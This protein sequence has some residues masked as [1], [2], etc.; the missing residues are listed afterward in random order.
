MWGQLVTGKLCPGR[1][2]GVGCS[3]PDVVLQVMSSRWTDRQ[4]QAG[5]VASE[6]AFA[7][8][9]TVQTSAGDGGEG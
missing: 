1:S 8:R 5:G 7:G 3:G 2:Q 4:S 6:R 9:A